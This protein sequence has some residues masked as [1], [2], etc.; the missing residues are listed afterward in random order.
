MQHQFTVVTKK[1]VLR[2]PA[3]SIQQLTKAL[4]Q[5]KITWLAIHQDEAAK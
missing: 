3:K 1:R 4:R 5:S 2:V